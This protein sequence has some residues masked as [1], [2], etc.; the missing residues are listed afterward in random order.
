MDITLPD[1]SYDLLPDH[2]RKSFQRY[3]E[4]GC[5]PGKRSFMEAALANKLVDAF[6]RAD[7]TNLARMGD[8]AAWLYNECPSP[9]W[10]SM[11]NI[12]AWCQR[13]RKE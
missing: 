13:F 12:A 11:E 3:V 10:G 4:E 8:I 1:I 7:D 2:M 5:P 9:A 6:A